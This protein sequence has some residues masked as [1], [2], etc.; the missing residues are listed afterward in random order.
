MNKKANLG[1]KLA[2]LITLRDV[3]AVSPPLCD[4]YVFIYYLLLSFTQFPVTPCSK[5]VTDFI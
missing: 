4:L 2:L 1:H 3:N 5:T